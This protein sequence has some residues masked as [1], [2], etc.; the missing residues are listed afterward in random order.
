MSPLQVTDDTVTVTWNWL[1]ICL[2]WIVLRVRF[3]VTITEA[4]RRR[5]H[6]IMIVRLGVSIS[7]DSEVQHRD[8]D[9]RFVRWPGTQRHTPCRL[10]QSHGALIVM[11]VSL[12]WHVTLSQYCGRDGQVAW[13]LGSVD[14]TKGAYARLQTNTHYSSIPGSR[15][16]GFWPSQ[17]VSKHTLMKSATQPAS[18]VS[19][20]HYETATPA[21]EFLQTP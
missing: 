9:Q 19:I 4:Y 18:V 5:Y 3:T 12:H 21:S 7:L 11:R 8:R 13:N 15:N 1:G 2:D 17:R 20:N 6:D 10:A 14:Q 16:H